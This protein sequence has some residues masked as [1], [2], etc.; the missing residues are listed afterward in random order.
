[1][2]PDLVADVGNTRIKWGRCAG[3]AIR[4]SISLP[5]DEGAW[6][7]QAGRWGLSSPGHWAIAGVHPARRDHLADWL[8]R[9]G[10]EVRFF[11][12]PGLL[13]LRVLL[14]RPDRVGIDRLLDAVAANSR[15]VPGI[16]AVVIDAGT[17][18]TVDWLDGTG[19]FRGGA[20][21]PGLRLMAQALHDY[22][23]LLPLVEAPRR[24]PALPGNA[25][26]PAIEAGIFW[27]VAGGVRGLVEA[28]EEGAGTAA[29]VFLTGGD[30]AVIQ[31]VLGPWG[32]NTYW[33]DM[34]LEGI[35]LTAEARS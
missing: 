8:R 29:Q 2:T 12:D 1:M 25:T 17:A 34:T 5:P 35:R 31:T 16:P 11:D 13:P 32:V 18:V 27:A 19:A 20:I 23:A 30:A 33:P 7:E 6:S 3:G 28:Y 10:D 21:M 4:E 9:R 22:T 14:E 26:R 24:M 15:R